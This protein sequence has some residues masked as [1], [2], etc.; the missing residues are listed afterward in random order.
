MKSRKLSLSSKFFLT[1]AI[2]GLVLVSA[3]TVVSALLNIESSKSFARNT[4]HEISSGNAK[5]VSNWLQQKTK[6]AQTLA[7]TQQVI[8]FIAA[9]NKVNIA[10]VSFFLRQQVDIFSEFENIL[11]IDNNTGLI[12]ADA[13]D[14][15]LVGTDYTATPSWEHRNDA[16]PF[17]DNKIVHSADNQ[18][19]T[20]TIS[21]KVVD[22]NGKTIGLIV[23]ALD[24][25]KFANQQFKAIKIA[26]TGYIYIIDGTAQIIF[27][28]NNQSLVMD[29]GTPLAFNVI[30]AEKKNIFQRGLFTGIWKYYDS[31]FI[32]ETGWMVMSSVFESELLKGSFNAV[33]FSIAI[34]L[35]VLLCSILLSLFIAKGVSAPII[36]IVTDL[37][38]SSSQIGLSSGQLSESSEEIANGAQEQAAGI[39]ETSSSMVELASM[40]KQNLANTRQASILSEKATE[41]S[42]NG[43]DKMTSMLSAMTGISK[44][45]EDIRNV[46]DVIDDISF[47]TNMLALNAAVEA[48]RAGEAGMGFAVVADE[49][50]N[51]ANRS[52]ESAK[53]TSSMIKETLRNVDQGMTISKELAEIFKEILT[54][55]KKVMEMNREVESASVQQ[56]EGIS[57]VNKAISQFDTVVQANASSS[58][59]TA[60]AAEEM[61]GQTGSLNEI[62][63]ELYEIITGTAFNPSTANN[64]NDNQKRKNKTNMRNRV[65][66][67][68]VHN[69]VQG[70]KKASTL[71]GASAGKGSNSVKLSH[72]DVAGNEHSISF[73]DDEEFK[74]R[75]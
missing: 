21:Q 7:A 64:I 32:P 46:I 72:K 10:T 70:K 39:E 34:A 53:E 25:M 75:D 36:N 1:V 33:W 38:E 48:A 57:Q 55:S 35:V 26:E 18:N 28:P 8:T 19:Y 74:D 24:W 3:T 56:D 65:D 23:L 41:A 13:N 68:D 59:E 49:V 14:S 17:I 54:N 40:V 66:G 12:I 9:K 50:K 22:A 4:L 5:V 27:H 43:F 62:V 45:S 44:S 47:Q 16:K 69:A 52:S 60:S 73:E 61:Q 20:F 15:P 2:T 67:E 42:Q 37:S 29:G 31:C 51:L 58:E 6:Q 71:G 63:T 30:A 11:I